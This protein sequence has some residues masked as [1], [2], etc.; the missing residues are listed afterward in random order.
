MVKE[1][2]DFFMGEK[3][4]SCGKSVVPTTKDIALQRIWML[5]EKVEIL[6]EKD[7]LKEN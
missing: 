7:T 3:N 6:K 2:P 4:G 5:I 1:T